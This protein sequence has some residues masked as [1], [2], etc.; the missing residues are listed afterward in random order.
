VSE[1]IGPRPRLLYLVTE[2]WYF[3]SHRLS[4]ARAAK[5]AGYEVHVATRVAEY[6]PAMEREGFVVHALPWRRKGQLPLAAMRAFAA[7]VHVLSQ[8]HPDILHNVALKPVVFGSAAARWVGTMKC[9]NAITGLGFVF[10]DPGLRAGIFRRLLRVAFGFAVDRAGNT[11]ILQNEDDRKVLTTG[12]FLTRS[13]VVIIRGSGVDTQHFLPLPEPGSEPVT[14]AAVTRMLTIKG[15]ADVVEASRILRSRNI[16]H[17]LRL[18]G[19]P[20]PDNPSSFTRETLEAWGSEPGIEWLGHQADVRDV[21]AKAHIAVLAS[22]GGEGLPKTLLEAAACARPIVATDVAGNREIA[23]HGVNA[24]LVRPHNPTELAEALSA[25]IDDADRR[26]AY[27]AAG[28]NLV[29]QGLSSEAVD[30]ETLALY[31]AL[32]AGR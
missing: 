11:A 28:R 3:W 31:N 15:V 13:S 6:G 17:R 21:W 4:L 27:G 9:V 25:L 5:Q 12:S 22:H 7:I 32:T 29:L 10:T 24:I 8:V 26:R 14:I 19:E 16:P 18:A 30:K 23:H 1:I 20:D 2:D